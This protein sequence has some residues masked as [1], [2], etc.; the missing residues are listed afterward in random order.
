MAPEQLALLADDAAAPP[1]D[2]RPADVFGGGVILFELLTGKHP[3]ATPDVLAGLPDRSAPAAALLEMQ[4][5]GRAKLA[6]LNPRVTRAVRDVVERCLAADPND[7]PAAAEL[8][9]AFSPARDRRPRRGLVLIPLVLALTGAVAALWFGGPSP[10]PAVASDA[11]LSSEPLA[12]T[13][14]PA[15]TGPFEQGM[16]LVKRGQHRLAAS[17]FLE[18]GTA[19]TDGR[20]YAYA[21]YCLSVGRDSKGA[22]AAADGAIRLG[23]R[24]AP[25]YANRAYNL[26]QLGRHAEALADCD[27]ALRLD[28]DLRAARYTR[29]YVH[30]QLHH[31]TGAPVPA[32]AVT[33]IERVT[34]GAPNTADVWMTAAE[35][36]VLAPDDGT[37]R[38]ESAAEAV[39]GA[40]AAGKPPAAIRKNLV[41][42]NAL[43][44]Y[45]SYETAL[46]TPPGP[47]DASINPHLSN[48]IP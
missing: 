31:L 26:Q 43:T 36:F 30:L 1:A 9:A 13:D 33:D 14:P 40:V 41:L 48:P 19:G 5:A 39:R 34:A 38:R 42:K 28:P 11:P 6:D 37:D 32:G 47:A 4:R 2:W 24:T 17:E 8:A 25:V 20:A 21:A 15:P 7:R 35:V 12:P 46:N 45:L 23:Y 18:A 29:A 10:R 44:R 16:L 27:E 22:A 3:F